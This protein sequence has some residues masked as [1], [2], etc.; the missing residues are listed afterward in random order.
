MKR[1]GCN[2]FSNTPNDELVDILIQ[3]KPTIQYQ[4]GVKGIIT[5]FEE[6]L[7]SKTEILSELSYP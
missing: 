3:D 6:S 1:S 2:D 7:Q 4:Q 5:I